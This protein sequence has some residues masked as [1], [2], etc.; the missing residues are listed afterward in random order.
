M[1][2]NADYRISKASVRLAPTSRLVAPVLRSSFQPNK[3]NFHHKAN[4]HMLLKL[5]DGEVRYLVI[6]NTTSMLRGHS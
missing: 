1:T 3:Q 5:A 4:G 2:L 6:E